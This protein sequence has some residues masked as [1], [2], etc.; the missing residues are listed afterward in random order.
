MHG[1]DG[2][3][4]QGVDVI[5]DFFVQLGLAFPCFKNAADGFGSQSFCS[6]HAN[7]QGQW[8]RNIQWLDERR[9]AH[10]VKQRLPV[11]R[12][13][14]VYATGF[15]MRNLLGLKCQL[16]DLLVRQSK[17]E[18]YVDGT[19]DC[20]S[21]RGRSAHAHAPRD[22]GENLD[23]HAPVAYAQLAHDVTGCFFK[24]TLLL[25]RFCQLIFDSPAW[26]QQFHAAV[27]IFDNSSHGQWQWTADGVSPIHYRVFAQQNNLAVTHTQLGIGL[28]LD[29]TSF[30]SLGAQ[31]VENF[32]GFP[33]LDFSAAHQTLQSFIKKFGWRPGRFDN[34]ACVQGHVPGLNTVCC[35]RLE[36]RE[37]LC[38][39]DRR[40]NFRKL[41]SGFNVQHA[42][43]HRYTGIRFQRSADDADL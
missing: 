39:T 27:A 41:G 6:G 22:I 8:L 25:G 26:N 31:V 30:N 21:Q 11:G 37:I 42:Q 36:C 23:A 17:L 9:R 32:L 43:I 20:D 40:H 24:R 38:Q 35:Q 16:I 33:D 19:N 28:V 15:S 5:E 34:A 10:S 29:G 14:I 13:G 7:N 12:Q 18:M 2:L 4:N 1:H 3:Q